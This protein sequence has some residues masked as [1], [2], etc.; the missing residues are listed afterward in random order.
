MCITITITTTIT[1]AMMIPIRPTEREVCEEEE[2][3]Q[4]GEVEEQCADVEEDCRFV[5]VY[6]CIWRN[7]VIMLKRIAGSLS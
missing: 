2:D 7:S 3:E 4:C 1:M 5:F 6:F